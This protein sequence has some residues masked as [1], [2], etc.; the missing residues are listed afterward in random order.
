MRVRQSGD[1]PSRLG[2]RASIIGIVLAT[3]GAVAIGEFAYRLMFGGPPADGTVTVDLSRP[4][5]TFDGTPDLGAGVDGLEHG[6][7]DKVWQPDN[8]AAMRSAGYGPISFRLRTELGVKAWH[9][10]AEGSFSDAANEQGYWTSSAVVRRDPGVSYG[11]NL[12]RRGNTIDQAKNDGYSRLDDGD[13][14]TFWKSNPYLDRHFTKESNAKQPQWIMVDFE[15]E[16]SVD[17]VQ[18]AWGDPRAT[19]FRVQYWTGQ[20][21]PTY[22][23]GDGSWKDFP[24]ASHAGAAGTQTVRVAGQPVQVQA[25]ADP[26]DRVQ[27]GSRGRGRRA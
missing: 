20:D 9:W 14:A 3:L 5:N 21:V 8:V 12:P 17:T 2:H 11:Y 27:R 26:A 13:Q 15:G 7:I 10:N 25:G 19:R 16:V 24:Q 4:V 22:P 6:E 18:I 23:I 1:R